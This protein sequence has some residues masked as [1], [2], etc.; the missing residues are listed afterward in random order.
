MSERKWVYGTRNKK[1]VL[2]SKD[3]RDYKV[4]ISQEH[5]KKIGRTKAKKEYLSGFIMR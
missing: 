5:M 1:W 2:V 4:G 3:D